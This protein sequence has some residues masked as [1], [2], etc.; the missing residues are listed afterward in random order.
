MKKVKNILLCIL[1]VPLLL[2]AACVSLTPT[3]VPPLTEELGYNIPNIKGVTLHGI[4][5]GKYNLEVEKMKLWKYS[6]DGTL[7]LTESARNQIMDL[8]TVVAL[9]GTAALPAA[10]RKLP[11]G[12]AF[13]KE[14][15]E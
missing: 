13:K 9:G 1:M 12:A 11:K 10:L 15:E 8:V 4:V 6:V 7:Q 14:E 5:K 2:L 3:I